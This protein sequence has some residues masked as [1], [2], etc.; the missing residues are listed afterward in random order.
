MKML[1]VKLKNETEAHYSFS[2]F[3]FITFVSGVLRVK[4]GDI[5]ITLDDV[6]SF[7]V[8]DNI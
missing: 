1:V 6:Y 3:S 8:H 4:G 5:D 2:H 7:E